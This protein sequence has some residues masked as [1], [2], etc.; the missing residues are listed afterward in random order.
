MLGLH[1]HGQHRYVMAVSARDAAIF[2]QKTTFGDVRSP[3]VDAVVRSDE[4]WFP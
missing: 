1:R 2:E 4:L 3:D